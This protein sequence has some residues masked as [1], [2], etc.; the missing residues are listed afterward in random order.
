MKST[1]SYWMSRQGL[2]SE[3]G[4][5]IMRHRW[6]AHLPAGRPQAIFTYIEN[7]GVDWG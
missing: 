4:S 6:Q 5:L 2:R 7:T 3:E 1:T